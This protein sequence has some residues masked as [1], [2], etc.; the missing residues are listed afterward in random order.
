MFIFFSANEMPKKSKQTKKPTP[1]PVKYRGVPNLNKSFDADNYQIVLERLGVLHFWQKFDV[2]RLSAYNFIKLFFID[3]VSL[4][5]DY[6]GKLFNKMDNRYIDE[7]NVYCSLCLNNLITRQ[8]SN[9]VE[10][11]TARFVLYHELIFQ[12]VF[13]SSDLLII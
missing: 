11:P 12:S 13:F 5:W 3:R 2:F 6:F 10:L 8:Q 7:V 9:E 4:A 1:K